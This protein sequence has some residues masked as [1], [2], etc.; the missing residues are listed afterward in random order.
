VSLTG[1]AAK[2]SRFS[3]RRLWCR[4]ASRAQARHRQI[5]GWS[6]TTLVDKSAPRM[7]VGLPWAG[8]YPPRIWSRHPI[9][10][11]PSLLAPNACWEACGVEGAVMDFLNQ[12]LPAMMPDFE[13]NP[14]APYR[15]RAGG[16]S[17]EA[18]AVLP[19]GYRKRSLPLAVGPNSHRRGPRSNSKGKQPG[20]S[21]RWTILDDRT[22]PWS[23][24]P[25]CWRRF[26]T[27]LRCHHG[28]W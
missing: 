14:P 6:K 20:P 22:K 4:D 3:T 11:C 19:V 17:G 10:A 25:S 1:A 8:A 21:P 13:Q 2:W 5:P 12:E 9:R 24:L 23:Q 28:H 15:V 27:R 18:H 7:G 26:R 16:R